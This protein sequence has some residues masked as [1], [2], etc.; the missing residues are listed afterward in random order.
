MPKDIGR[1]HRIL[2]IGTGPGLPLQMLLELNPEF[3]AVAIDPSDVAIEHL[4]RRFFSDARVEIL[5]TSI[6]DYAPE[7]GLFNIAV[8]IG[9]SHHLDTR[10]F[11]NSIYS[12]LNDDGALIVVD[13]MLTPFKNQ[14]ER[15]SALITHHLWYILDTL[16]ELPNSCTQAEIKLSKILRQG[17]PLAMSLA[18]S[19]RA[20]AAIRQV[21]STFEMAS[22]I[23]IENMQVSHEAVF[24]Q[25]H[26]LELQALVAGLDYEVEQKT[27]P[28]RFIRMAEAS[29]FQLEAHQRIYATHGDSALDAGTHLFKFLKNKAPD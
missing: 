9:A 14:Q 18:L 22:E 1:S 17:L 2:D 4:Q 25:F 20:S 27:F 6:I 3:T 23:I 12:C 5:K 29:G 21:R 8:S 16:L 15:S 11:F 28:E 26:M 7:A 24:N 19:N 10:K 13:E